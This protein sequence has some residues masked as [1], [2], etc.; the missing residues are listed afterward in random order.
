[1]RGLVKKGAHQLNDRVHGV[2]G[3]VAGALK[4]GGGG[5]SGRESDPE[6]MSAH[7]VRHPST[8]HADC[9]AAAAVVT[10]LGV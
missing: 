1:M 6:S 2:G 9:I 5:G 8:S 4:V 7:R 3:T 10:W